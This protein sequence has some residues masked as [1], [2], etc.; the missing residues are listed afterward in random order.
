MRLTGAAFHLAANLNGVII[1]SVISHVLERCDLLVP[2][3]TV[4]I[5]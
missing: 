5:R 1:S 4:V 3:L 2:E